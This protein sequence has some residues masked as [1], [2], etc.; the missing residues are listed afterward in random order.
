[1]SSGMTVLV[2][3]ELATGA[4]V[5]HLMLFFLPSILS[6]FD[7][8]KR[9]SFAGKF[10]GL[11]EINSSVKLRVKDQFFDYFFLYIGL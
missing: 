1:M 7:R 3:L 11:F 2:S 4:M 10:R 8:P 6:V 9:P 5:L